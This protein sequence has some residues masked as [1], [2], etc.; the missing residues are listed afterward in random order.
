MKR[1]GAV[2]WFHEGKGYGFITPEDGGHN[3]F[4]HYSGILM[5]GFKTLA[6]GDEVEFEVEQGKK[7]L[8]AVKVK[9]I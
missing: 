3:V 6:E 4:V 1:R 7:G 8:Q 9:V 5:E 2:T